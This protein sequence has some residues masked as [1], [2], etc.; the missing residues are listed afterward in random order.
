[1]EA[2][3]V[4]SRRPGIIAVGAVDK[5]PAKV[6][7]DLAEVADLPGPSGTIV[8][9]SISEVSKLS[10]DVVLHS[11]GSYLA[12]VSPQLEELLR[13]DLY[14]V[15][16]CEELSYPVDE[17]AE[18]AARLDSVAKEHGVV[19]LG[20]GINPGFAMDALPIFLTSV[21]QDVTSIRVKRINDAG[22]RRQPLRRKVGAGLEKA[23]FQKLVDAKKVRHVGLRESMQMLADAM[24]WKVDRVEELTSAMLAQQRVSTAYL[25]V[26]PG[27]VAGVH[28]VGTAFVAD[29][30]VITLELQMYV[31]ASKESD[32]IW[33]EG[34]PNLHLRC[35]DGFPGDISTTAILVN[36]ATR[37]ADL[38]PGLRTM[39]DLPPAH[40]RSY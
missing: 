5:D 4:V 28:Q 40:Y 33:I 16:T 32:E 24:G 1:M 34:R 27:Q 35:E 10:G 17:R 36:A 19:L 30:P 21:S 22:K 18:I 25:T 39:K 14:V 23:E 6:G 11:T 31:G 12:E 15:S 8:R 7:R 3:R 29:R 9:S 2:A 26:E 37:V 20:T 38:P 13:A